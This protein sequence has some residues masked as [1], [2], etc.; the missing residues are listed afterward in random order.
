MKLKHSIT[1]LTL[2]AAGIVLQGFQKKPK[3]Y[4]V[5]GTDTTWCKTLNYVT[6]KQGVL[7]T[8]EYMDI[9]GKTNVIEGKDHCPDVATFYVNGLIYDKI[10]LKPDDKK[11]Y[12]YTERVVDGKLRVYLAQKGQSDN[13]H[14]GTNP[15]GFYLFYIRMP[16]GKYYNIMD[17]GHMD[18]NIKPYMLECAAFKKEYKGGFSDKQEAFIDA[19]KLYNSLCSQ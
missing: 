18:K 9:K 8:L 3:I 12:R 13:P 11:N 2:I 6:N 17:K 1:F 15:A 5:T 4:F 14:S 7:T 10:P 16:D 19:A